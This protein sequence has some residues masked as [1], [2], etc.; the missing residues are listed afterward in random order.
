MNIVIDVPK[1][2]ISFNLFSP[3]LNRPIVFEEVQGTSILDVRLGDEL[4]SANHES[5]EQDAMLAID[6]LREWSRDNKYDLSHV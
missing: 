4:K 5:E 2:K 1:K 3:S 6:L